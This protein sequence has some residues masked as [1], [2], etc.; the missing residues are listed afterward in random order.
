MGGVSL[1]A[2]DQAGNLRID[3]TNK[4]FAVMGKFIRVV[5]SP[6]CS[7]LYSPEIDLFEVIT[8]SD[9]T[10]SRGSKIEVHY[11]RCSENKF[12]T[13]S[14]Y[15]LFLKRDLNRSSYGNIS[16]IKINNEYIGGL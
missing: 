10:I 12:V 13:S 5:A 6:S 9:S 3:T 4:T 8:S 1:K 16:T 14:K 7:F 11:F 15:S 2:Q